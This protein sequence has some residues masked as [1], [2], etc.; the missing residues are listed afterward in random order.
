MTERSSMFGLMAGF[1]THEQLLAAAR[2]SHDAGYR[3]LDAYSPFPIEGLAESLGHSRTAVPLIVLIGGIVGC[4]GGYFLAWYS[5]A[6][7]Y[8]LNIG[9]RPL[10]SWPMFIPITFEMTILIASISAFLSVLILNRLPKLYHPVFN[11][12]EFA[13]ASRDRFF[14]CIESRDPKFDR[15]ETRKFLESLEPYHLAE[16]EE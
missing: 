7:D 9:G 1:E 3:R 15:V 14:L 8:P 5:M 16:V 13:R 6:V 12:E 11:V 4:L 2:K 10:N